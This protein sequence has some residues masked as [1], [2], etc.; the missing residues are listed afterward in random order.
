MCFTMV[1]YNM[2]PSIAYDFYDADL[3]RP[4]GGDPIT[5]GQLYENREGVFIRRVHQRLGS[6]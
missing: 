1:A 2:K 3:G 4:I 6:L 5:K